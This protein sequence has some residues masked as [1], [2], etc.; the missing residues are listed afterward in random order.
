[1]PEVDKN[2]KTVEAYDKNAQF[3][4]GKFDSY[5]VRAEDIERALKFNESGSY[6]VLEL[7]CGSGRDARYIVPRVGKANY[8]GID[9]S[10]RLIELAR[11]KLPGADLRVE[12]MRKID[13]PHE[14]LGIVLG[15]ASVLHVN[16]EELAEIV[17][18][19]HKWLKM[20][21]ILYISTKYGEYRELE[22]ENLGDKKYYYP[23]TPEDIK[24][25]VGK[26]FETVYNVIQDSDY[27]PE[28]VIA[29][30]KV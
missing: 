19:C 16:R 15:F 6:K 25:I 2:Q 5:G 10:A 11:Q 29:L 23:Y 21:G 27:G 30:R 17:N 9:A 14:T 12:D 13:V 24:T 4:A 18:K 7:G 8:I 26:G 22:I 20:G 28:L 1:M 3:Y